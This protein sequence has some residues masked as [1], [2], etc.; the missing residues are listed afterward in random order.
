MVLEYWSKD[1][2]GFLISDLGLKIITCKSR[3]QFEFHNQHSAFP[4]PQS[5]D[6]SRLPPEA[7]TIEAPSGG[8]SKPGPR[9]PDSLLIIR[10]GGRNHEHDARG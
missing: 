7:R 3:T 5:S 9:G 6:S 8:G 2:F 1:Y 4:N 10:H